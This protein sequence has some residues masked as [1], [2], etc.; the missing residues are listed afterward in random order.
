[1]CVCGGVTIK[2]DRSDRQ[3][4]KQRSMLSKYN[5]R[6]RDTNKIGTMRNRERHKEIY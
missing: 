2:E 3:T 6:Q 4:S 1:M 5:L